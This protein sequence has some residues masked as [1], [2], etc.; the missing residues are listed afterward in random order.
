MKGISECDGVPGDSSSLD[1]SPGS[2]CRG[3]GDL[4]EMFDWE[5]L[6]LLPSLTCCCVNLTRIN[7]W[8]RTGGKE[9][10]GRSRAEQFF[11]VTRNGC[12]RKRQSNQ[13]EGAVRQEKNRYKCSKQFRRAAIITD[14][15]WFEER[16]E[17]ETGS[18][19]T[20]LRDDIGQCNGSSGNSGNR[21]R[22]VH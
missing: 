12:T 11:R 15:F 19:L 4:C 5:T 1:S 8:I 21:V 14:H 3:Q 9:P 13:E 20:V 16:G 22:E 18:L 10:D 17:K 2:C 7:R 6:I